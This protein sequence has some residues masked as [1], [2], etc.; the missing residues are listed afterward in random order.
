MAPVSRG[1][2][3]PVAGLA[4][5]CLLGVCLLLL[6]AACLAPRAARASAPLTWSAPTP[7][8]GT[9]PA[10]S[11]SAV[12]CPS[13]SLCVVADKSGN[14]LVSSN[15]GGAKPV[16]AVAAIDPG[17]A[18]DAL[19]CASSTLCIAVDDAGEI[20]ASVAPTSGVSAWRGTDADGAQRLDGVSCPAITLCVAVDGVG[21]VLAS[22]DPGVAIPMW[23]S[24]PIDNGHALNAV[25][26]ASSTLC[27][28][29]DDAGTALA[30]AD[31]IAQASWHAR[32]IDTTPGLTAVSCTSGAIC[33]A[34]DS[35][36]NA[37]ASNDPAAPEPTWSSTDIDP[38]GS[39]DGVSC[40]ASGRCMVVDGAG[41]TFSSEAPMGMPPAWSAAP[42]E[43]A[44]ALPGVSC[45]PGV[46][47]VAIDS[48][49]HTLVALTP[50]PAPVLPPP[51]NVA[52]VQPRPSIVGI[53]AVGERLRCLAG[54]AE[55]ES[56]TFGYTW[57]RNESPIA[58]A[59]TSSYKVGPAD[60]TH[61]L[62]CQ[63]TATNAGGSASGHSAFVAIPAQG[64][65]AAVGE[66]TV[67]AI[68]AAHG[69]VSVVVTCSV[70]ATRGCALALRLS[71]VESVR[72]TRIL[73][74]SSQGG[75]A[76]RGAH[77]VTVV[78]GT[79][80]VKLAAGRRATVSVALNATGRSLL[81][82]VH[83][84]PLLFTL[85]GTV[86]GVLNAVLAQRRL[87]LLAP[88]GGHASRHLLT[89]AAAEDLQ[90]GARVGDAGVSGAHNGGLYGGGARA[91]AT[92]T[93]PLLAA[94]PYMGWDSYF[95]FGGRYNEAT[96]LQQ[97]SEML[98]LHL[99]QRGYRY[100]WLDAGWWHG[101]R[102]KHGEI[103]V[104]RR[105]WPH[106]MAWLASTLHEAG[107]RVGLYTDAGSQGCGGVHQGSYD[108]YRLD[109][110][111]FAAWGFDAVKVDFCG[112]VRQHLS[113]KAAY[114]SFHA[115]ID[116]N[117]SHRP[118]LLSICDFLEPG[119]EA[120]NPSFS[121]SAFASYTFGPSVGNSWRTDTDVGS[122]GYVTFPTVL[123]NLDADAAHPEAA[124]PGHWNDPDYLGP[125]QGLSSA[126]FHTQLSMWAMLA[127]PLMVSDD[128]TRMSNASL[129]AVENAE[130]IAIDQDP[131]GIQGKLLASSGG[132]Q[133]WVKPLSDGSR[134]VA[135]LNRG[136]QPVS[137][138]TSANAIGMGAAKRYEL[139]NLWTRTSESTSGPVGAQVP[140]ESTILLRV[141]AAR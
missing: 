51:S 130:V 70:Q 15:P 114:S 59:N 18:L 50:L 16:W 136:S 73:R 49:G 116:N 6:G 68:Q 133:V 55:E 17:H 63:V 13:Q 113:P 72:G 99:P 86:I 111:T 60:A 12:S 95:A 11:P 85:K 42:A 7:L 36:G 106:G 121:Q 110:N 56:T 80:S 91:S 132:G 25:S 131:A 20:F 14:V 37:L 84:L 27:V 81:G 45:V 101:E 29:V 22:T 112:G 2:G 141:S 93:K 122:P 61:H 134:A 87:A 4:S 76:P 3:L 105:Q 33:V 138:A 120:G 79:A 32:A 65:F 9:M 41:G 66:T 92:S 58:A 19:S 78:L 119:Q 54:V 75:T 24:T 71:A 82:H 108:H 90:G 125:D 47:C 104:N 1:R 118:M 123:R 89:S 46:F 139:R 140:G 127:A 43:S 126:Q 52:L 77:N 94:T 53:P 109:A 40:A 128:L 88:A 74:L 38:L 26:C 30:S 34:V 69:R 83:R 64:V 103:V 102:G 62:Q 21:N 135:L 28:A 107:L 100:V 8:Y 117:S 97:A 23:T 5:T 98:S 129:T 96:I 39:P 31:P 115:A 57:L 137:I 44:V 124:G 35:S 48:S 10:Q 67:G